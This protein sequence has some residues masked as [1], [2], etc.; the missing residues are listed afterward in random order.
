[1]SGHHHGHDPH[2]HGHDH[3]GHSH[4]PPADFS[5]AFI[6]GI[7][8]NLGFVVVET[9]YGIASN[10]VALLADAGHNLSDVAGLAA[11]WGATLR[12]EAEELQLRFAL[13]R[14]APHA[15]GVD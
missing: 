9:A 10:S 6:V 5:T 14:V 13:I 1:M 11:A 2:D 8:L 3:H 7:A 15:G 4:A 12:A